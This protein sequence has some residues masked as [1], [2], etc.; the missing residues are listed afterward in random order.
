MRQALSDQLA[1]FFIV[2]L[3]LVPAVL[4]ADIQVIAEGINGEGEMI[5]ITEEI[6]QKI[7][8]IDEMIE[9]T[10]S[11]YAT[12]SKDPVPI[13]LHMIKSANLKK[14]ITV[15][16]GP[17]KEENRD[18][19]KT[20]IANA[21]F[22]MKP[23]SEEH[24]AI[25]E[26]ANILNQADI[27]DKAAESFV[28]IEDLSLSDTFHDIIVKDLKIQIVNKFKPRKLIAAAGD[29]L[30][31][32]EK[33]E[34]LFTLALRIHY[35][36]KKAPPTGKTATIY[37]KELYQSGFIFI[38]G[39]KYTI[40][41]PPGEKGHTD[42]EEQHEVALSPYWIMEAAVTQKEYVELTGV[43]PSPDSQ[44]TRDNCPDSAKR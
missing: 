22:E 23:S 11:G 35:P 30:S 39:G 19:N 25:L 18:P 27:I 3:F 29:E 28:E 43:N 8:Y 7:P 32:K 41:S 20:D 13:Y 16:E 34:Q 9:D 21:L 12:F 42:Y 10:Y 5:G 24:L 44:K 40:G 26:T 1:L 33:N 14:I 17:K 4:R 37:Y 36:E 2:M 31:K 15:L 6:A 38:P